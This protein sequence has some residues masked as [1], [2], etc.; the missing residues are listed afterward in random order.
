MSALGRETG[1]WEIKDHHDK[2]TVSQVKNNHCIKNV[3]AN[4]DKTTRDSGKQQN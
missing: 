4:G 2:G 3:C 1:H